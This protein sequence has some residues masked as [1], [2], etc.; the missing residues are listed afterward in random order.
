[1]AHKTK[2]TRSNIAE[3]VKLTKE[4]LIAFL[5]DAAK[6]VAQIATFFGIRPGQ[7]KKSFKKFRIDF[8]K[9]GETISLKTA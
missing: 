7:V 1:M 8:D 3:P 6:T 4:A 9:N 2:T 5:S